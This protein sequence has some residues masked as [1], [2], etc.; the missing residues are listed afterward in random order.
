MSAILM[1]FPTAAIVRNVRPAAEPAAKED[2]TAEPDLWADFMRW[3]PL[4][5]PLSGAVLALFIY[6]A[7]W[8]ALAT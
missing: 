7:A 8:F 3:I 6:T 2:A 5:V 1:E 4:V